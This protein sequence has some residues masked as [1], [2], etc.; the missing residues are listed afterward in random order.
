M[1]QKVIYMTTDQIQELTS[2]DKA[3]FAY[4]EQSV[5]ENGLS[6]SFEDDKFKDIICSLHDRDSYLRDDLKHYLSNLDQCFH[7]KCA[8]IAHFNNQNI[9]EVTTKANEKL[10]KEIQILESHI[11]AL[12]MTK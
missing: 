12:V 9:I 3:N 6:N 8:R 10:T 7:F 2:I 1:N 11:K 5:L 4:I